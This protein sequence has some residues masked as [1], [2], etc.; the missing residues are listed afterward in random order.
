MLFVH[1]SPHTTITCQ[2]NKVPNEGP[3]A[4][5]TI[6][7]SF[8]FLSFPFLPPFVSVCTISPLQVSPSVLLKSCS[9]HPS[10]HS[11]FLKETSA[12]LVRDKSRIHSHFH[13]TIY[14][15]IYIYVYTPAPSPT[16]VQNQKSLSPSFYAFGSRPSPTV[17]G[18]I[19][20]QSNTPC[21]RMGDIENNNSQSIC[22]TLEA[23]SQG[24]TRSLR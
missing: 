20:D 2:F 1:P 5:Y 13:T 9:Q 24:P 11:L 23:L 18:Q 22:K 16:N 21:N 8:S 14:I 19:L 10:Q 6:L 4:A 15:Y 7:L 12:W 3:F 17:S